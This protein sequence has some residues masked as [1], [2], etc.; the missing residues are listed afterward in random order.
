[1]ISRTISEWVRY[2]EVTGNNSFSFEQVRATFS[3]TSEQSIYNSLYRLTIK[4]RVVSV[5]KGFYVITP[6]Q[7]AAKGIIPPMY[8]ID[9]LM[10]YLKK[11][12]YIGL[13]NA[14]ELYGA[15]HQRT[16]RFSIITV[17]P[18]SNVSKARNQIVDWV[19]RKDIP[20]KYL[21]IKNSETGVVRFSNPEL[22]ALDLVQY[23][24]YIGGLSRASTVLKEL[25]E[26]T[27]FSKMSEDLLDCT[28]IATIQRLG[29]IFEN[30][31]GE[32]QQADILFEQ[33]IKYGKRLNYI[34]LGKRS[35]LDNP[36]KD[37]R[38]K[39]LINTHLETDEL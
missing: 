33:L 10:S 37:T 18:F 12:Y 38:W 5:Y 11:P 4:N 8:Y 39:I 23:E 15:A 13:L 26:Q 21:Q 2:L 34:P 31:L 30:I 17:Y 29:F 14:A 3:N 9:Q 35:Q 19:F 7:Y 20:E 25:A 32:K 27:D 16:Q 1:M 28:S 24:S 6:P 36:G 22:T